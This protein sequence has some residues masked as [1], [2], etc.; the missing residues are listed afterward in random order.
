MSVPPALVLLPFL[1]LLSSCGSIVEST[2]EQSPPAYG[3]E[4]EGTVYWLPKG[5]V[6]LDGTWE[7]DKDCT[8]KVGTLIEADT[9]SRWRVKRKI[10]H[11]FDDNVALDVDPNTG[12]LKTVNGTSQDRTAD[13]VATGLEV[14]A[15]VMAFGAG[16]PVLRTNLVE[17]HEEC[18]NL[19]EL[20]TPFHIKIPADQLNRH[21][22]QCF[23][24]TGPPPAG[25]ENHK[26]SGGS[27]IQTDQPQ[28]EFVQE[29]SSNPLSVTLKVQITRLDKPGSPRGTLGKTVNGQLIVDGI[30]VRAPAPYEVKITQVDSTKT[31][32]D[33]SGEQLVFLPDPVAIY[34]LPLDRSPFVK[35][36]TQ[37]ALVNGVVQSVTTDR[38]SIILG[39]VGVP[40]T[41]LSALVPLK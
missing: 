8:V 13:I 29:E 36:G 21:Y 22:S 23:R 26:P 38:P 25:N 35:N 41:I 12:L 5:S 1:S 6:S 15:R 18:P 9:S 10:N 24:I 7:K 27:Q 3:S 40:K 2:K 20:R 28:K 39:I 17:T 16:A 11:L 34:Y 31:G 32:P 30:V 19:T 14:A 4:M 37:I 33:L